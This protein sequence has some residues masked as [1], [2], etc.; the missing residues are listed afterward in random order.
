MPWGGYM[1]RRD[2]IVDYAQPT[3][4][5][6]DWDSAYVQENGHP[7]VTPLEDAIASG[8]MEGWKEN[9]VTEFT[10]SEGED[11]RN[12][13]TDNVIFP[14]GT[15]DPLTISDWEWMMEAFARAIEDKG[16]SGNTD[17]Y[18]TTVSYGGFFGTGEL[19]SSFGGGSGIWSKDADQNVYFSGTTDNFRTYLECLNTW[20]NNGWMDTRF[21]TRA[22][23]MFFSIN[24]TGTAQ[25]MVGLFYGTNASLGDTIRVTC[26]D[27]T[28]QQRAYVMPCS[29]PINDVHGT[30]AQK[31]VTPDAF[32]QGT[33]ISGRIGIGSASFFS[34]T[35]LCA[36]AFLASL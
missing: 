2:W 19:V 13:Y 20:Y 6:W 26:A 16:F 3:S 35:M 7:A 8:N 9:E 18:C 28:D 32:Y 10:S 4:H 17:A 30:D 23:D 34:M 33:R 36:A 1:Y 12:D 11:P 27:P 31:Y 5:V 29:V 22:S 24:Q 15:S 25:G 14:S 21:E